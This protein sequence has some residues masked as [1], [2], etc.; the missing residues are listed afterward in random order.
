MRLF[1]LLVILFTGR[2]VGA[3]ISG[4]TRVASGL[5]SPL[6]AT[7]APGD[8]NHLFVLEKGGNIKVVDLTT[9]TV[10]STPFLHVPDTDPSTEGGL[11]GLAF[12]PDYANVGS[13]GYGKFYVYV[14]VDNGGLPVPG[15]TAA[16]ATSPFSTHIRQYTVSSNPYVANAS[17]T[18][19]MTWPRPEANHV[20]GWIGFGPK[21]GY[22]YINSGDGG[23]GY[24]FGA[25]HY[26]PGGNA[27][28][29]SND[30]ND[31]MGKQL[32]IDVSSDDFPAD[33]NRNYAIP[34]SNP[35]VGV[36][37][38]DEIWSY[39][40]RNPY[41]GSF[42]RDT[43]NQ[44]IADV[45]QDTEEEIDFEPAERTDVSNFGWRLREG[46][47]Q[48]R[49]G[50]GG[51]PPAHYVPPVYDYA[52]G[53]GS[54]QGNA[55][56]G[57]YV[58]RGP[59]PSLQGT[60]I[61]GDEVSSHFWEMNTSTYAVTNI[62]SMLT[63]NVGSLDN[64]AAFAEDMVG[65]QYIVSYGTGSVFRINTTQLLTGDY[66]AN[67][68]VDAADFIVWRKTLGST[69]NLAADGNNSG[70]VDSGDYT[71][72]RNNFGTTVH[73]SSLGSGEAVPEP[74]SVLYAIQFAVLVSLIAIRGVPKTIR[75]TK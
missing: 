2:S 61:F 56:I 55:V 12:S 73:T 48:T 19:I 74:A 28:N 71:V 67:G 6:F 52:H 62:D 65:N 13:S 5:S 37:G 70:K 66:N 72:W 53:N 69:T 75:A 59:D 50:G 11:L 18:E 25:G 21:D 32:R 20:G 17:P 33:P 64:P 63:P 43:G 27:Q 42:D 35:F 3:A 1:V 60:Y 40:L 7:F 29:I 68:T 46:S 45:G 10:L 8:A 36:T 14:T 30:P 31:L 26:E 58:Y 51:P 23:S 22:L 39:G 9:K 49:G 54:L 41:R 4:T 24:D 44:W 47:I 15:R 38:A 16:T 34:P 57:G